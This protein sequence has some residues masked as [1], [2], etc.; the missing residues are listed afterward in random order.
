MEEK[1]RDRDT[2]KKTDTNIDILRQRERERQ[3]SIILLIK[4]I[5][6]FGS[7]HIFFLLSEFQKIMT[8]GTPVSQIVE[9]A[10]EKS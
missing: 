1:D 7:D 9:N 3:I 2:E 8:Q 4:T 6:M 5:K 10:K